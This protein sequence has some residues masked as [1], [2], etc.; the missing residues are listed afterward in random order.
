MARKFY[1]LILKSRSNE[2]VRTLIED[3]YAASLSLV[4]ELLTT[5][6]D[7]SEAETNQA[8]EVE[9]NQNTEV[10]TN[11][12]TK[13]E[14]NQNT[15]AETDQATEV[16][17]NQ[18]TKAE[19]NQAS[20]AETNQA[21]SSSTTTEAPLMLDPERTTTKA[22]NKR[23]RGPLEKKRKKTAVPPLEFGAITPNF[24][25]ILIDLR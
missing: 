16:E 17:T 23:P 15:E 6:N 21:T 3:S 18:A 9:T 19:T 4:E 10:E 20:E 22:R 2:E 7:T 5:I 25:T 12:A 14:T 13:A 1:N 8:T 24:E 11:Q